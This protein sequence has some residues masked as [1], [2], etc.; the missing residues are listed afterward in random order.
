LAITTSIHGKFEEIRSLRSGKGYLASLICV[1]AKG[2]ILGY[3]PVS[4]R[5]GDA[6]RPSRVCLEA[7][8][9]LRKVT[10]EL[11]G[12]DPGHPNPILVVSLIRVLPSRVE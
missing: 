1:R 5:N 11:L 9:E 10:R 2:Q 8:I 4:P 12:I 7:G 6:L 3:F